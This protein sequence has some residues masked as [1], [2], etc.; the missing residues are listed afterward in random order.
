MISVF[1][2]VACILNVPLTARIIAG[3]S[4]NS[5]N[6]DPEVHTITAEE[7]HAALGFH[8]VAVNC[9]GN[10]HHKHRGTLRHGQPGIDKNEVQR[11]AFFCAWGQHV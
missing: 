4:G 10:N 3:P 11:A 7:R 1:S 9:I 2:A 8:S 6:S 5:V